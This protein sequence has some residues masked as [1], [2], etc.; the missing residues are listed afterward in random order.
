VSRTA[1]LEALARAPD[2][3]GLRSAAERIFEALEAR[4]LPSPADARLLAEH[5]PTWAGLGLAPRGR[6]L[7]KRWRRA[8]GPRDLEGNT[9]RAEAAFVLAIDPERAPPKLRALALDDPKTAA[10]WI[11]GAAIRG[12]LRAIVDVARRHRFFFEHPELYGARRQALWSL[13]LCGELDEARALVRMED[14]RRAPEPDL[15]RARLLDEALVASFRCNYVVERRALEEAEALADPRHAALE[16]AHIDVLLAT[17]EVRSEE[18]DRARRRMKKWDS[19]SGDAALDRN[20]KMVRMDLAIL[21]G[22]HAQAQRLLA[23]LAESGDHGPVLACHLAFCR[24]LVSDAAGSRAAL[25]AYRRCVRALQIAHH[26]E[27]LRVIEALAAKR[28]LREAR[29]TVRVGQRVEE[30]PLARLWT[31]TLADLAS[32][33]YFDAVRAL[34][35]LRG[36]GPFS[37]SEQPTILRLLATVFEAPNHAVPFEALHGAIWD[38][39]DSPRAYRPFTHDAKI[40]VVVHRARKWLE[41][42]ARGAAKWI[43]VDGSVVRI[44]PLVVVAIASV[45]VKRMRTVKLEERILNA[46]RASGALAPAELERRLGCSRASLG[47]SLRQL[48]ARKALVHAGAGPSLRYALK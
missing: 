28:T 41:T 27:R 21:S 6:T 47:R 34:I 37:L 43:A 48:V 30:R 2:D 12:E 13:L 9:E 18:L 44:A 5:A 4:P 16:R 15:T 23:S 11:A 31:P 22:D 38:T 45:P 46:L 24:A 8:R 42:R 32:D 1:I 29:V 14:R 20:R 40:N 35:W 25:V 33:I 7:F 17:N 3:R 10:A 19:D 36:E 26:E 39:S